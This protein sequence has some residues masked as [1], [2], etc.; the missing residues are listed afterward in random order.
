VSYYSTDQSERSCEVL[1]QIVSIV[2]NATLIGGWGTWVRLHGEMSHDVDF[3]VDYEE[4]SVLRNTITDF[5]TSTHVGGVKY[6]GD[7]NDIHIDLYVPH[8]SRLGE[9]LQ[10]RVE[11]LVEFSEVVDGYH[12]LSVEAHMA[13]KTAALLD[14]P[15]TRPGDK[16][17]HELFEL[18]KHFGADGRKV[19]EI[20]EKSSNHSASELNG[21]MSEASRYMSE[22][23]PSA[24]AVRL[25]KNDRE[26]MRSFASATTYPVEFDLTSNL[27]PTTSTNSLG[28]KFVPPYV[29]SDGT[30]V[31]G[32]PNPKR[33]GR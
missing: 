32:Y 33:K 14:R 15:D 6:R 5:P 3:I 20:I 23:E 27:D 21:L 29:R 4:L 16:D 18:M 28:I 2:P 30:Q 25:S 11:D 9:R 8:Q 7:Y 1:G 31:K 19:R 17:R 24:I 22:Y 12:V 13:S 26:M 10:L